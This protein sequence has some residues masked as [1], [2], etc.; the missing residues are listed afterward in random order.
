MSVLR[1]C[2]C[3]LVL[4]L[5][6]LVGNLLLIVPGHTLAMPSQSELRDLQR[7]AMALFSERKPSEAKPEKRQVRQPISDRALAEGW[8]Q[9]LAKHRFE[10][11]GNVFEQQRGYALSDRR[12]LEQTFKRPILIIPPEVDIDVA[13]LNLH[14]NP[15]FQGATVVLLEVPFLRELPALQRAYGHL[16]IRVVESSALRRELGWVELPILVT[17]TGQITKFHF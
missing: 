2:F 10:V 6:L 7:E 8:R 15:S 4:M 3:C 11:N 14:N 13:L 12:M 1:N 9:A 17:E 16:D 5:P